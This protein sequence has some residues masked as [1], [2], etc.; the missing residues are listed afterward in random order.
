MVDISSMT[1]TPSAADFAIQVNSADNPDVWTT[2]PT[3][4]VDVDLGAGDGGSDRV[5]LTWADGEILNQWVEVTVLSNANTGLPAD[6]MFYFGNSAG[7]ADGDGDIDVDDFAALKSELGRRGDIGTLSADFNADG[8]VSLADFVTVRSRMGAEVQTP[9]TTAS[10]P[11]PMTAPAAAPAAM[12]QVESNVIPEAP[13]SS[14]TSGVLEA[15][16]FT[17]VTS[18]GSPLANLLTESLPTDEYV[19]EP[20]AISATTQQYAA[21]GEYDLAPLGDE[22]AELEIGDPLVDLLAESALAIGL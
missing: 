3:P 12:V 9:T 6:D 19:S 15:Y 7:D 20:Q 13:V 1:G 22:P 5:I 4:T 10:A 11:A 18:P 8:R 17:E 14:E 16:W 21:T 2:G